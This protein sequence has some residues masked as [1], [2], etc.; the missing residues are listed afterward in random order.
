M[1]KLTTR[2]NNRAQEEDEG[3][4]SDEKVSV[5][6]QIGS[7]PAT[8]CT[9]TAAAALSVSSS[10]KDIHRANTCNEVQSSILTSKPQH[11]GEGEGEGADA[12]SAGNSPV[13]V[14]GKATCPAA[15]SSQ[16]ERLVDNHNNTKAAVSTSTETNK[17]QQRQQTQTQQ[18]NHPKCISST[19]FVGN[20]PPQL[21][22]VHLQKLFQAYG[23]VKRVHLVSNSYNAPGNNNS[24]AKSQQQHHAQPRGGPNKGFGFV[25]LDSVEAATLAMH[26]IHGKMLLGRPLVVRPAH[27]NTNSSADMGGAGGINAAVTASSNPHAVKREAASVE[28]KIAAVKRALQEKIQAKAQQQKRQRQEE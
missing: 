27:N 26:K 15:P 2:D 17:P 8:A 1:A 20:L 5:N 25:E 6:K 9:A 16:E 21:A 19:L 18:Y 3:A 4:E 13:P 7:S 24:N 23:E 10:D 22:E 11:E 28:A 14:A 12:K